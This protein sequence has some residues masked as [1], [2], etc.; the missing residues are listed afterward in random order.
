MLSEPADAPVAVAV[1]VVY[2]SQT[3]A[4]DSSTLRVRLT[5]MLYCRER[6]ELGRGQTKCRG[7]IKG[8]EVSGMWGYCRV[9]NVV[10][11]SARTEYQ[12]D[13]AVTPVCTHWHL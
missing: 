6:S 5:V 8:K 3:R 10:Y 12:S 2:G 13:E 4:C 9:E 11:I 7:L 1:A